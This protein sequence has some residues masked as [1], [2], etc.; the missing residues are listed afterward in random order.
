MIKTIY[1]CDKLIPNIFPTSTTL[2]MN[3]FILKKQ[4]GGRGDQKTP[5]IDCVIHGWSLATLNLEWLNRDHVP[6]KNQHE[7]HRPLFA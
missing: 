4:R 3:K 6:Y 1:I 2:K 7:H 5:N